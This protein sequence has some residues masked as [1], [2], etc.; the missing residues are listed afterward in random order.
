MVLAL[1]RC[2][3]IPAIFATNRNT[4]SWAPGIGGPTLSSWLTNRF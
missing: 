1:D 4:W 2:I 3:P